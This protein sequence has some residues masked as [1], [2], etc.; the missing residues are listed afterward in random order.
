M[1]VKALVY[2]AGVIGSIYAVRLA[3]AGHAVS[4]L[5]RGERLEALRSSGL[6]IRNAFTGE[7]ESAEVEILE[8]IG[9]E[10]AFDIAIVALRSGQVTG[11]LRRIGTLPSLRAIFVVGNNL[12]DLPE[13]A[14]AAGNTRLILGFG[15]FGGYREGHSIVYL[16]GRTKEQPGAEGI[17]KTTAGI[18]VEQARPALELVRSVLGTAGLGCTESPDIAAYLLCHA[19]LVFPLAGAIFAAGGDQARLCRTGDAIILGIRACKEAFS[20]LRSSGVRM[21]PPSIRKLLALPE[22]ILVRILTKSF[23]GE[24]ARIAMFGHANAP[25]RPRR[26]RR[27]GAGIGRRA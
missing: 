25:G 5:A 26:D 14:N 1:K 24:G 11:A 13:E 18:L 27:T 9:A 10:A 4:V 21:E 16:D 8:D 15:A 22:W 20:S 17:S 2:G 19:A 12:E 3:K 23:A 7:E 6:R